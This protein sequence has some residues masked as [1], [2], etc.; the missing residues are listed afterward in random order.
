MDL[1]IPQVCFCCSMTFISLILRG[2]PYS[3]CQGPQITLAKFQFKMFKHRK[4]CYGN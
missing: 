2:S 4:G 1:G 3:S